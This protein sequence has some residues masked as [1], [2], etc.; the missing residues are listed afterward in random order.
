[1]PRIYCLTILTA[2][3]T[4]MW[5]GMCP[6]AEYDRAS[7]TELL[8]SAAPPAEKALACKQL[9]I[10]GDEASVPALAA[11]LDDRELSSWARIALEA[12]PGPAADAALREAADRLE[13]RLL[14]G[15][16]NSL[17]V[18][19]DPRAVPALIGRLKD[20]DIDVAAVSALALG[21]IASDAATPALEAALTAAAPAVRSAAAEGCI[22]CAERL[23]AAGKA[24]D[25]L[26][27]YTAVTQADVP[28]QRALEAT[29]GM[30]LVQGPAG[31]ALL[32]TQLRSP[33][34]A[35]AALGLRV[36]R[37]LPGPE[38]AQMLIDELKDAPPRR[39]ALLI[40]ALADRNE[41]TAAPA[42]TQLVH[43]DDADVRRTALAALRRLGDAASVPVLLDA[44]LDAD[45]DVARTA[46]DVLADMPGAAIDRELV[47]RLTSAEGPLRLALIEL[48]GRRSITAAVG[49]LRRTADDP[50][51]PTRA[52]ALAAL[53]AT[54]EL[55][56]LDLLIAPVARPRAD[57]DSAVVDAALA[58]A[59]LRLA[60]RD[61]ATAKLIQVMAS[62]TVPV[63][64]RF[65]EILAKIGGPRVLQMMAA[66]VNDADPQIQD[67]ASRLLGEWMDID[68]RATLLDLARNA[69]DDKYKIR[70]IRGYIRLVRQ[71]D[72]PDD[73]RVE[74]CRAALA[75][76]QRPVEKKL[77]LEVIGRYPNAAMLS[78]ALEAARTP[79][80]KN[81]AL[82][83]ALIIA[84]KTGAR[85]AEIERLLGELGQSTVEIEIVK[86]EYG[87]GDNVKDVT[88]I[89]RKH[90][91]NF[92]VVILPSPSYNA[93]FG[94]DPAPGVVKQL[95]IQY[96][97]AGKP[98]EVTLT[99]NA[100]IVLPIP[101]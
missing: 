75:A 71:F 50:D 88:T 2:L 46:R 9:A 51:G 17:G 26:R 37:E 64:C 79:E 25:A 12:I 61:A 49:L 82:A 54:V 86:A 57:D 52:A 6:A 21:H 72:M 42:V 101:K 20:D 62:A 84:D 60:D 36:A 63:R 5:G 94:G 78:L 30:I 56:D 92:P 90:V 23:A 11:L 27:V 98:S 69:S 96:R 99:E 45:A 28:A 41:L 53:G 83:V 93:T 18:R 65:L 15:V 22:L 80:L 10:C 58:N 19:R 33:D 100:T 67:T 66:A 74:M 24:A 73:Q 35:R 14:V 95:R 81:E 39:Q 48:A 29:R 13:G 97:M 85:S 8:K 59:C 38:A 16:I 7:L 55:A 87:A 32:R 40:L 89:L 3:A 68:A 44:A 77:V 31:V 76:A 70:A 34:P 1:M 43:S 47:D 4:A 91:R